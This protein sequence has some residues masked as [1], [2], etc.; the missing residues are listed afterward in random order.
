MLGG[1]I[2][3]RAAYTAAALGQ[4]LASVWLLYSPVRRIRSVEDA[5]SSSTY[6]RG[7]VPASAAPGDCG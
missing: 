7:L 4:L 1:A 3:L 6:A 2:G 5:A